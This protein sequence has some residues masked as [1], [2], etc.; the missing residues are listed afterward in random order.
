MYDG[1]QVV[2]TLLVM[3]LMIPCINS[4]LVMYKERGFWVATVILFTVMLYS[5]VV[6][7]LANAAFR[8]LG[9]SF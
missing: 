9:A 2:V 4:V 1:V 3:T 8:W 6:G 7:G 5:L